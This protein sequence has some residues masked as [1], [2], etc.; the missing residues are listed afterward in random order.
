MRTNKQIVAL[1]RLLDD[2]D[3]E[4]FDT[5]ADRL[6]S[7]GKE[8]IPNLEQL[9]EVTEDETVQERIERLIHRALFTELQS[10]FAAWANE[11][12]PSLLQG[13]ILLAKYRYPELNIKLIQ[14]Q[15][16]Q[17]RRNIW[18]ELNN[19]LTPLEQINIVNSILYNYYKLQGH[20]ITERKPDYFFFNVFL[21]S[22]HGNAYTLGVLYLALCELLD[23]PVQAV[24]LPRQFVLAYFDTLNP[25]F[26][27]DDEMITQLQFYIDPVNGMVY[28]QSDVDV[29][30]KKI[31]AP[32]DESYFQPMS[33]TEV[34][35]KMI[36][37]LAKCYEY[38]NEPDKVEELKQLIHVIT[39]RPQA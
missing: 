9:W 28:T 6:L 4:V 38:N 5:V 32:K 10:E 31:N 16:E 7:Y 19:Y 1:L 13:A 39:K 11:S 22:K 36:Q 3:M 17:M 2:P 30:L 27:P 37:E 34:M 15:F 33:K 8:I 25:F 35:T 26:N 14:G 24:P 21:E 29:Y 23:V 20:E 18:L 12:N